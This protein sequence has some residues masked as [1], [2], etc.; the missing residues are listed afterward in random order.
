[1]T[2]NAFR[3]SMVYHHFADENAPT[4]E[5]GGS[6]ITDWHAV[7]IL[8]SNACGVTSVELHTNSNLSNAISSGLAWANSYSVIW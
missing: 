2:F 4:Q 8:M 1:M 3:L 7:S 5:C 6:C